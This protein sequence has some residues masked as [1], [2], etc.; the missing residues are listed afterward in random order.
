MCL[1]EEVVMG[2]AHIQGG[3]SRCRAKTSMVIFRHPEL[4]CMY[5]REMNLAIAHSVMQFLSERSM[6]TGSKCLPQTLVELNSTDFVDE[7]VIQLDFHR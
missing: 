6:S 2:N 5:P 7:S 3:I 4:R 1:L